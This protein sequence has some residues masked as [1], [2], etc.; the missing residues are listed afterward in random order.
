MVLNNTKGRSTINLISSH[1]KVKKILMCFFALSCFMVAG[2]AN[3]LYQRN[4]EVMEYAGDNNTPIVVVHNRTGLPNSVGGVSP[5]IA[6]YNTSDSDFKYVIFD[7]TPYNRVG[8]VAVSR[9]GGKSTAKLEFM[10]PYSPGEY[11]GGGRWSPVWYS[12]GIVCM[13]IEK[14]ELIFMDGNVTVIESDNLEKALLLDKYS[15]IC[16]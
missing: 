1:F 6:F 13:K 10:G 5:S 3:T 9:V 12:P 8:D 7:V 15:S 16:Q 11:V 4:Q 14:I 2:C